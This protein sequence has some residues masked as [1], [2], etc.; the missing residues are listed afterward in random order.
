M[1]MDKK[2]RRIKI[3]SSYT[4]TLKAKATKSQM[5]S[6]IRNVQRNTKR[7]RE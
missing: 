5:F 6:G 3:R 1:S 4:I 7:K 2:Q